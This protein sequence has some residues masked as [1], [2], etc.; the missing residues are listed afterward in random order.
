M[1]T[2]N[3]LVRKGRKAPVCEE[4][5]PCARRLAAEARRLHARLHDHP[6]E[7]ELG[8]PEGRPRPA[9]ERHGDRRLHPRRGAQPPGALGRAR[10]RR[11]RQGPPGL[12]LQDHPGRARHGRRRRPQAGA[13]EVRRE[14]GQRN[15]SPCRSPGPRRSRATRLQLAARHAG[16]QQGHARR[17]EVDRRADRLRRARAGRHEDRPAAGRGARA[18]REDGHAGPRGPAAA[19]SAART[20]RCRSRC[21]SAGPARSPCAG[22]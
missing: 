22:S 17:Q 6:E 12:P 7:A 14:E 5:D 8:P 9:H 13:L 18:G 21:R 2:V 4:Q 11:P 3:Q 10:P 20:T 16:D 15:A 1:P 19:A